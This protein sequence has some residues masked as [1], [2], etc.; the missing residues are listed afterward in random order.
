MRTKAHQGPEAHRGLGAA[1]G[2]SYG[3]KTSLE[4]D[5]ARRVRLHKAAL[6]LFSA[7]G[8]AATTI[9]AMCARARVSTLHFYQMF[10]DKEGDCPRFG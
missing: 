6:D 5:S 9:D 3:G 1:V 10:K 4:R 8:F 7:Q 2:R